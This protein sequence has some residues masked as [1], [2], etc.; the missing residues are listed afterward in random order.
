MFAPT[1][2]P[3]RPLTP[4]FVPEPI[5]GDWTIPGTNSAISSV[6]VICDSTKS[7][8]FKAWTESAKSWTEAAFF[9]EVTMTSSISWA[10]RLIPN[11]EKVKGSSN[12]YLDKRNNIAKTPLRFW[13]IYE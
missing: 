8:V 7:V 2:V 1:A 12:K 6:S 5:P 13:F 9:V 10:F 4:I 3:I 11:T